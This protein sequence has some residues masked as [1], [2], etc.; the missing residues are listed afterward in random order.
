M[1]IKIISNPYTREIRFL[2]YKE[3]SAQWE[4]IKEGNVNSKLREDE[5]GK[6]FLP[7]RIKEIIDTIISE[8]Y[9]TVDSI[10]KV[11]NY[12]ANASD[13]NLQVEDIE[14]IFKYVMP[15]YLYVPRTD[16]RV[17]AVMCNFKFDIENGIAVV[18]KNE[19][20][21]EIGEQDI[22]L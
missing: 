11:K 5:S 17:I 16:K 22:V 8:Y 18:Y 15:K 2:G 7:F 20:F 12:I 9:I 10:N 6:N 21:E 1:T 13:G 14:N 19:R 3:Q 4:D